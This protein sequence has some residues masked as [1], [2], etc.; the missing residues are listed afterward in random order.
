MIHHKPAWLLGNEAQSAVLSDAED[1]L[2]KNQNDIRLAL[3]VIGQEELATEFGA[4][5][6]AFPLVSA[7][8]HELGA[9][10]E[11][12]RSQLARAPACI[13]KPNKACPPDLDAA[14]R[15]LG[16]RL[17]DLSTRIH[18]VLSEERML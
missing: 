8:L 10:V 18:R 2:V 16:A 9:L 15:W 7:Q 13:V 17:E 1:F 12:I 4:Q 11:R 3:Q 14:M 6:K 5:T